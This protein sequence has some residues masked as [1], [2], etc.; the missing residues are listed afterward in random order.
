MEHLLHPSP[1]VL[2]VLVRDTLR[3]KDRDRNGRLSAW[4]FWE[5]DG[6]DDELEDFRELDAWPND[7]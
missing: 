5:Q 1:A 3:H 6:S 4:E 7:V 2:E